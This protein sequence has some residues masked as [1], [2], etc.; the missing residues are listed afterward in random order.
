MTRSYFSGRP[1][2]VFF[3]MTF[4]DSRCLRILFGLLLSAACTLANAFCL[5]KCEPQKTA[6]YY[7]VAQAGVLF[8]RPADP[9][10]SE[11]SEFFILD[12]KLAF[13]VLPYYANGR[14]PRIH[15]QIGF[16]NYQRGTEKIDLD[17]SKAAL[18]LNGKSFSANTPKP[19]EN[20]GALTEVWTQECN[21]AVSLY[22][23]AGVY[24]YN[25]EM[26][27]TPQKALGDSFSIALPLV[28]N[29]PQGAKQIIV[30]FVK[31]MRHVEGIGGV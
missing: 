11:K 21:T 31:E 3:T 28:S 1:S 24:I 12:G 18:I 14:D 13:R 15:L 30:K 22:D 26:W 9:V 2:G 4:N 8:T 27:F 17:C 29:H 20:E 5:L 10:R 16:D 23:P 6:V 25:A 19:R 7:P